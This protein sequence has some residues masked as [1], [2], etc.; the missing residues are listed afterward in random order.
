[1]NLNLDGT[2]LSLHKERVD[3]WLRG[4]RIAPITIDMALTQKCQMACVFCVEENQPITMADGST[5]AIKD[6]REGDSVRS[7]APDGSLVASTVKK[8]WQSHPKAATLSL[9]MQSSKLTCTG[10]HPILTKKGWVR[11]DELKAGEEIAVADAAQ[12]SHERPVASGKDGGYAQGER[13]LQTL[14]ENHQ[15]DAR[16]RQD[17]YANHEQKGEKESI[18][19]YDVEQSYA[20]SRGRKESIHSFQRSTK[21][22]GIKENEASL[23]GWQDHSSKA[24]NGAE[25]IRAIAYASSRNYRFPLLWGWNPL[26]SKHTERGM[27]K[28]RLRLQVC[29][30]QDGFSTERG[31][32]PQ[33]SGASR[34]GV[35]GLPCDRM[36]GVDF[37]DKQSRIKVAPANSPASS[38]KFCEWQRIVAIEPGPDSAVYDLE[39]YPHH[40]F[41]ASGIVVHNCYADLQQR[42]ADPVPWETYEQFLEDCKSIGHKS[43]EGVKAISLVSDGESTL[44]KSYY[45]FIAKAK[46]LGIDIASGTNGEA[47]KFEQMP[48]LVDNLTYL[49]FNL[50]AA[51]PKEN[52]RIMGTSETAFHRVI[53]NVR[54]VV[55][56]KKERGSS[57]S[58][59]LQM[60]LMPSYG[61][62]I[63]PLAKFGRELGVDYLVIKHC[64]DDEAGRLGVDYGWYTKP[65]TTELLREAER[66]S[67][68]TYSVQ[69]KW[70]KIRT[71]RDR[72]YSRCYGTAL[73]LQMSG[74][75]LVAPC[76]SFFHERY[77]RHHIGD[78][79]TTRFKEIWASQAYK[80][81]IDYLKS[82]DFD[83]RK[84]CATLCLQDRTNEALFDYIHNETAFP[85]AKDNAHR[86]FL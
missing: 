67:T 85:E 55:R 25:Q 29:K 77:K 42:E 18:L 15:Q 80:D 37:L 84:E 64:S 33:E 46:S 27:Q 75:G 65:E 72:K 19:A 51:L 82:D 40:N 86:N 38:G 62:Q 61:N 76:G 9:V 10:D 59:G 79:A 58:I 68:D 17:A 45:K 13:G 7:V 23:E 43:G 78:I 83:P 66:Q 35:G 8:A 36:E 57:C 32:L 49:R 44:N 54:E 70:S 41:V 73:H 56:L 48:M 39:V 52:A 26:D 11:A 2:K 28:S 63:V 12:Q 30:T 81:V 3:A 74:T 1:M 47:L 22:G 6:V 5:K 60:V 24:W 34:Q 69:V 20:P 4:E 21:A 14:W 71:G 50:N 16:A 31:V 53:R